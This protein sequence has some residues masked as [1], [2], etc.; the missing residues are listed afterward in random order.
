LL[1]Q[2]VHCIKRVGKLNREGKK[3]VQDFIKM[4]LLRALAIWLILILAESVHGVVRTLFLTPVTGDFKARQIGV[5]I[6]SLLIL[7]IA[8]FSVRWIRA[9]TT[10]SLIVVGFV[11]LIL[12]L[13]FEVCLGIFVMNLSRERILSDY[14]I[15]QGG[16]MPFGLV[17]L[18][19]SPLIA[20]K[21]RGLNSQ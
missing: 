10:A 17:V 9:K 8:Y 14:N 16:F 18:M 4:F 21:L 11:W 12:T 13:I 2:C 19:F 6:G 3:T 7:T 20:A 1:F 5:F 15:A